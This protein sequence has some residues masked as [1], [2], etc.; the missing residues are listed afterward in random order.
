MEVKIIGKLL[1]KT[2]CDNKPAIV[3]YIFIYFQTRGEDYGILGIKFLRFRN[4]VQNEDENGTQKR[5]NGFQI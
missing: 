4:P 3:P 5:Q 1:E 2:L